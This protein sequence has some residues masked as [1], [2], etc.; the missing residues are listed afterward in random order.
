MCNNFSSHVPTH[1][2]RIMFSGR[3]H[4]SHRVCVCVLDYPEKFSLEINCLL[5]MDFHFPRQCVHYHND[6]IT[7]SWLSLPQAFSPLKDERNLS[8]SLFLCALG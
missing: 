7:E 1:G 4:V 3:N 2:T 6:D 8:L 5:Q